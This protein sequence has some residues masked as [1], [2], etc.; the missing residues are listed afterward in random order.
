MIRQRR[1]GPLDGLAEGIAPQNEAPEASVIAC[2]HH[3]RDQKPEIGL[4]GH[5]C[6]SIY[7]AKDCGVRDETIAAFDQ[8]QIEACRAVRLQK[9]LCPD[10]LT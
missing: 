6:R 7:E 1:N 8:L 10:F 2:A 3:R 4:A 9:R 5:P